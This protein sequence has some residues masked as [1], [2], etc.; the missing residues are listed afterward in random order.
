MAHYYQNLQAFIAKLEEAGELIR[1]KEPVSRDLEISEIYFRHAR[2]EGGGKAL[3]FERVEGSDFP[4]LINAFGS[5]ERL[6]LAFGN[7]TA[8]RIAS[9]VEGV[10]G[11]LKLK[12]PKSVG[13]TLSL[14]KALY[15]A[16][17]A[18]P[19]RLRM[20][21][22]PVQEIVWQG[23][24]IDLDRIPIIKSW[25]LD[26]GRFV[27][28]GLTVTRSLHSG[29]HNMGMYRLQ[30]IS[31]TTTAMHWQIHKDG[32]HFWH[33]YRKAGKR[34]PVSVVIGGD[35]SL[36]FSATAPLPPNINEYLLAGFIRQKRVP[37]VKGITNDLLV[38]AEA[39]MILE[40][41]VDPADLVPEGPFG[42]HTGYYTP[43]DDFPVF[44]IT[45]ITMRKN[46][47]YAATVVGRSPQEDCY[48]AHA[49]ERIFLPLLQVVSPEVKD[50]MLP[51]DGNFHNCAVFALEKQFPFHGRRLMNHLWGFSQM[52]F[53]R[54]IVTV[55][56]DV[57]LHTGEE[58]L[59]HILNH[60]HPVRD[61]YITE[62]ILDQLDH[63]GIQVAFGGKLGVDATR[64]WEAEAS[65]GNHPESGV[66]DAARKKV[67]DEKGRERWFS[68]I[69]TKLKK[70]GLISTGMRLYG[71]ELK[72]PVL[73][74]CIDKK[75]TQGHLAN[76]VLDALQPQKDPSFVARVIVILDGKEDPARDSIVLWKVFGNTEPLRDVVKRDGETKNAGPILILDSTSKGKADGYDRVWP[77][78][79]LMDQKTI[80]KVDRRWFELFGQEPFPVERP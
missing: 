39:E 44:H 48:L 47:V 27:T 36:I 9:R 37:V 76:Q 79:N 6:K 4:V 77:E 67:L 53:A 41:Y 30:Q 2:S 24:E 78:E 19:V 34:M 12:P 72:N 42:D 49:T 21:K 50:Q 5:F 14:A 31:R 29:N 64:K 18:P 71:P 68:A 13:Q 65:S 63:S 25:P 43:V 46:P 62:G 51:W 74:L 55:D 61:V 58:L 28:L 8:D 66:T 32:S 73:I 26:G 45:A 33:E 20:K 80:Q 69:Q 15:H 1:I 40:G 52:S 59:H 7:S 60:T 35:P 56:A 16:S 11:L 75:K 22:A 70:A 17:K 10:T 57:N 3:L 54:S 38:P 23:D